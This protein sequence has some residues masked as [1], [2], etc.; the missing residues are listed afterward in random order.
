MDTGRGVLILVFFS[1]AASGVS[2]Q[3]TDEAERWI[4]DGVEMRRQGNDPAAY[5]LFQRAFVATHSPR[6]AAQIGLAE[7]ALGRWVDADEHLRAA[8]ASHDPWIESHRALL[9]D[10]AHFVA[11]HVGRLQ[12][13]GTAGAQLRLNGKA[14]GVL[15]LAEP[16]S[17]VAGIVIVQA[18]LPNSPA[19][20][21]T[22]VVEP[23][24]VARED[25]ALEPARPALEPAPTPAPAAPA[26]VKPVK[27]PARWRRPTTIA[28]LG[29]GLLVMGSGGA[30]LGTV[31]AQPSSMTQRAAEQYN[32]SIIAHYS[33]GAVLVGVGAASVVAAAVLFFQHPSWLRRTAVSSPTRAGVAWTTGY[34]TE[35]F[36]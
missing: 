1:C 30:L 35:E 25:F 28:L 31:A 4:H 36:R 9:E 26:V 23:D 17:V 19:I 12:V 24:Q 20:V 11:R 6:A 16:I 14:V 10:D 3:P 2:A 33:S 7:Q 22:V 15:P 8:L 27:R 18:R 34:S 32:N 21:R 5:E 29:A 13:T